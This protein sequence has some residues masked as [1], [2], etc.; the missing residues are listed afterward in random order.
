M[1]QAPEQ[2]VRF[3]IY[4][5]I[6]RD[7][8]EGILSHQYRCNEIQVENTIHRFYLVVNLIENSSIEKV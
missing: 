3:G 4:F 8:K 1:S 6:A 5:V 2:A 7:A